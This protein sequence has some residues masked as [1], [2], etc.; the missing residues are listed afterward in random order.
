MLKQT[1]E[2]GIKDHHSDVQAEEKEKA[3]QLHNPVGLNSNAFN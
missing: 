3:W 2:I 1:I